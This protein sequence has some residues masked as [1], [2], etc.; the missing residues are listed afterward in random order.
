MI[1]RRDYHPL[2]D[3]HLEARL[4]RGKDPKQTHRLLGE[5]VRL[6]TISLSARLRVFVFL[7]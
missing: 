3:S 5:T 4:D 6:E 7:C 2:G 1:F